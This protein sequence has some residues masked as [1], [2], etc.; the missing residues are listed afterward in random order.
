MTSL[1]QAGAEI[2][3]PQALDALTHSLSTRLAE[4]QEAPD[5][6]DVEAEFLEGL[7]LKS[8]SPVRVRFH[9]GREPAEGN[10]LSFSL[11]DGMLLR[12]PT[13]GTPVH[14]PTE[15]IAGLDR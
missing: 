11:T 10:L 5:N 9:G 8:G 1:R 14:A 15:H 3:V 7:G 13:T 2:S 6:R 12:D 4:T